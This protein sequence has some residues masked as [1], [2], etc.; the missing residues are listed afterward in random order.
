MKTSRASWQ[1]KV[2]H[3]CLLLRTFTLPSLH[4]AMSFS[5][6]LHFVLP[7][8]LSCDLYFLRLSPSFAAGGPIFGERETRN[9]PSREVEQGCREVQCQKGKGRFL[10]RKRERE[11]ETQR[12]EI[13]GCAC[14]LINLYT[15]PG[16]EYHQSSS[17]LPAMRR[18]T[19]VD[20]TCVCF[21]MIGHTPA[22]PT[23]RIDG[24]C[25]SDVSFYA[26]FI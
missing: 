11:V 12:V 6:S 13:I 5:H 10:A 26:D 2:C 18:Y 17:F 16:C 19:L 15:L 21:T 22:D 23:D 14:A 8:S 1:L 3:F 24:G 4:R 20:D 25:A 9:A 7:L